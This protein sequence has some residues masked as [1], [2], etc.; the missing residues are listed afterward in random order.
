MLMWAGKSIYSG[1]KESFAVVKEGICNIF[2][3]K[4]YEPYVV[5]G[6]YERFLVD[7]V[8]TN[9]LSLSTAQ[10][11]IETAPFV[12]KQL[13]CLSR[14]LIKHWHIKY[15]NIRQLPIYDDII[16]RKNYA[17]YIFHAACNNLHFDFERIT[18][19]SLQERDDNLEKLITSPDNQNN[20]KFAIICDVSD[21]IESIRAVILDSQFPE[22][23]L[24]LTNIIT[25]LIQK[26]LDRQ[27][28]YAQNLP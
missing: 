13:Y 10:T 5:Q 19:N 4:E 17:A 14:P 16:K 12:S 24:W 3:E 26:K 7:D 11:Q 2:T 21:D 9:I 23:R 6:N 22:D 27:I 18:F 8:V 25:T 28:I 20:K 1:I 15:Q